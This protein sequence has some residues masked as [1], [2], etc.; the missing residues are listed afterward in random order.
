MSTGSSEKH[1]EYLRLEA[2]TLQEL[3]TSMAVGK[4]KMKKINGKW[5]DIGIE[6]KTRGLS[7]RL[8]NVRFESC[9]T[10]PCSISSSVRRTDR[11][12]IEFAVPSGHIVLSAFSGFRGWLVQFI[13]SKLPSNTDFHPNVKR[14]PR[15]EK[16]FV[17]TVKTEYCHEH[18]TIANVPVF[19]SDVKADGNLCF[20][21]DQ[22]PEYKNQK[23][24]CQPWHNKILDIIVHFQGIY[25]PNGTQAFAIIDLKEVLVKEYNEIIDR[26]SAAP[27]S[28]PAEETKQPQMVIKDPIIDLSEEEVAEQRLWMDSFEANKPGRLLKEQLILKGINAQ[29]LEML[30]EKA[31]SALQSLI[32]SATAAAAA[33]TKVENDRF[34][35]K[36][37]Y[38][39]EINVL[40]EPCNHTAACN[41]CAS[42]LSQC[43]VCRTSIRKLTKFYLA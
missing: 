23:I 18:Q 21:T 43:P 8:C 20:H 24:Q 13:Q 15:D 29:A 26:D 40:F 22:D 31:M 6:G 37:C 17:F 12:P 5:Y 27:I 38:D 35:C 11:I 33:P 42:K 2:M 36:I 19:D 30:D 41:V 28:M 32:S 16:G 14:R 25:V 39:K 7:L 1:E 9:A 4:L 10:P 34:I 3:K